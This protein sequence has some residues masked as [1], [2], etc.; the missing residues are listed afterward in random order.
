MEAKEG[1][2]IGQSWRC[3]SDL[4]SV[5]FTARHL[6]E[7]EDNKDVSVNSKSRRWLD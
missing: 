1:R 6:E 2:E 5:G 3:R 4:A 7:T